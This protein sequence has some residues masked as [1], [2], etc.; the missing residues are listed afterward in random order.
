MMN[1]LLFW[2]KWEVDDCGMTDMFLENFPTTKRQ[3]HQ[4][5]GSNQQQFSLK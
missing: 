4:Q 2:R 1:M 5:P 3:V